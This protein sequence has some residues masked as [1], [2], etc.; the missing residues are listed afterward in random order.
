MCNKPV[1][2]NFKTLYKGYLWRYPVKPRTAR[3][4]RVGILVGIQT[5][6]LWNISESLPLE[7]LCSPT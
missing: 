2:T 7:P 1:V 6:F 4:M 5:G 3:I